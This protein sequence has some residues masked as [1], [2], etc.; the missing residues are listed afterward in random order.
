MCQYRYDDFMSEI[1]KSIHQDE[2]LNAKLDKFVDR[3]AKRIEEAL[4]SNEIINVFD[5]DFDKLGDNESAADSKN[6]AASKVARVFFD[7]TYCK[8]KSVTCIKFHPV[9]TFLAAVSLIENLEFEERAEVSGKSYDTHVLILNF[10]D[11]QVIFA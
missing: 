6:S 10:S 5:S 9:K 4:Q 11:P 3:V 2:N 1:S 7:Q 8:N